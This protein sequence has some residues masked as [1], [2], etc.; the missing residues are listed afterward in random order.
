MSIDNVLDETPR[1]QYVAATAQTDF[2]YPFAIFQDA[3]LVVDVDGVT[4]TLTTDYTVT[5]E[6]ED[7][8]GTVTFLS[9][10]GNGAIVTIYRDIPIERTSD[11]QFGGPNSSRVM[12]DELDR[13]TLVQQQLESQIGRAVRLPLTNPQASGDLV[14]DAAF[15]DKY[16]YVNSDGELEPAA[17]VG[18]TTLTQAVV[19]ALLWPLSLAEEAAGLTNADVDRRYIWGDLRRYGAL[20]DGTTSDTAAWTKAI[21]QAVESGGSPVFHSGGTT[22]I[23]SAL[24][25]LTGLNVY[26]VS[27]RVSIIKASAN[28]FSLFNDSSTARSNI[29]FRDIGFDGNSASTGNRAVL[30]DADTATQSQN[31]EFHRCR[32]TNLFRGAELDRVSGLKFY[33]CEGET[34]NSSLLYVGETDSTGR[35]SNVRVRGVRVSGGTINDVSGGGNVVIAYAD[36][37]QVDDTELDGAGASSGAANLFHG[38]YLR[39]CTDGK[40]RDVRAQGHRRGAAVHVFADT[41]A[42]EATNKRI[43][44][45]G[46]QADE[47]QHYAAVRIDAVEGLVLNDI[48]AERGYT[49]ACY[50][51]NITGLTAGNINGKNNNRERITGTGN[52]MVRLENIV[53]AAFENV[54]G[55]DDDTASGASGQG[56]LFELRGTNTDIHWNGLHMK[57]PG[58]G[59]VGYYGIEIA[60]GATLTRFSVNGLTQDGASNGFNETGTGAGGAFSN[61]TLANVGVSDFLTLDQLHKY[62][63]QSVSIAGAPWRY[64]S[65]GL[66]VTAYLSDKPASGNWNRD[67]RFIRTSAAANGVPGGVCVTTHTGGNGG[68]WKYEAAIEA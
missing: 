21:S 42:G 7:T 23:D 2:D 53:A 20:I 51:T 36:G 19:G 33:D 62:R 48:Q 25:P 38:V 56:C 60:S 14:L 39:G 1:V 41:G 8:G 35:S 24:T 55:I 17:S 15:E 5:G 34:L 47:Q 10:P 29:V 64:E 59:A 63:C 66:N 46:V 9:A 52:A 3:D 6:G 58:G 44:V 4:K 49:Q 37:V 30:F 54:V 16:L 28:S 31:I 12:N 27:N 18:T 50:L 57:F 11:F 61:I 32:F 22:L 40:V 13:I 67:D 45:S 65:N 68:T 26:G 43:T